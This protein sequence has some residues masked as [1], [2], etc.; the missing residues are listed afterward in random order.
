MTGSREW[1]N[2]RFIHMV[3]N[4]AYCEA[5]GRGLPMTLV[6]GVCPEGADKFADEWAREMNRLGFVVTIETHPADWKRFKR[7]AG[8]RRNAEMVNCGADICLAF[9]HNNSNGAT[10]TLGLAIQA[11]IDHRKF[12]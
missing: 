7:A 3:L 11:G 1:S 9:I 5:V 6:H 10:H 4:F 12:V 8:Y 2:P